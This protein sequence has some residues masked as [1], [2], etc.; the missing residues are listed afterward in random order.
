MNGSSR[1]KKNGS[2][3]Y[4]SK[5]KVHETPQ[6][7]GVIPTI[8][9]SL[10]LGWNGI[11]LC[12][13]LYAIIFATSLG[14]TLI[15]GLMALSLLLPPD[16][17][18]KAGHNF[19]DWIMLR[20]EQ[21][22]GL[23]TIIEDEEGLMKHSSDKAII[24]AFSPHDILP[25]GVFAFNPILNRVPGGSSMHCL[26]TSVIFNIPFLKHVYTWVKAKPVDKKTFMGRLHKNKSFTFCP[27]GVQEVI[28][29]D[30]QKPDDLVLF[31]QNRKGFIKLALSTGSP[32]VPVFG[33]N[34]DGTFGYWFPR[35]ALI[36]K[37]SRMIGFLP[38]IYWGR[39]GIPFGIPHPKRLTIVVGSPID[40]PKME[41]VTNEKI[42][43][44][45]QLFV[46]ELINLFERHKHREG[47][48]KKRLKIA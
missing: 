12:L 17:P 26:M 46:D 37:L 15:F 21:Y 2:S 8:A 29:L 38:M 5:W 34:L 7:C 11:V 35:G 48:G 14:R 25:F 32:I 30:P 33:F 44:Y 42:D 43:E 39:F 27:G 10:W 13:V 9:V 45:H 20:A 24:Y 36:E 23:K 16:F 47:Y 41:E 22:F 31:L 19:G 1:V 3:V 4:S 18:G 6:D 28:L 40:V